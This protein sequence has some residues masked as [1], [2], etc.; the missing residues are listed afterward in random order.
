MDGRVQ[1]RIIGIMIVAFVATFTAWIPLGRAQD[2]AVAVDASLPLDP[3]LA[4][5]AEL[6]DLANVRHPVPAAVQFRSQPAESG[7]PG[8]IGDRIVWVDP[9][10][11]RPSEVRCGRCWSPLPGPGEEIF[12]ATAD[13]VYS[14]DPTMSASPTRRVPTSPREPFE[15]LIS[16]DP[17]SRR[18]LATRRR[19]RATASLWWI[20]LDDGRVFPDRRLPVAL[21]SLAYQT[22]RNNLAVGEGVILDARALAAQPSQIFAESFP[23]SP[24]SRR[25]CRQVAGVNLAAPPSNAAIAPRR[26]D[27]INRFD[28]IW[29]R[30]P[31]AIVFLAAG[32]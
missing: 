26:P 11:R 2:A 28:P 21:V 32:P 30:S 15:M 5:L 20:S 3:P 19:T 10:G 31:C 7:P 4:T 18:V 13:G 23:P 1:G 22:R 24:S 29:A 12:F 17:D 25:R 6:L 14:V 27:G 9:S 8:R 16:Y